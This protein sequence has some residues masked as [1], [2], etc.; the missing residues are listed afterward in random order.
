M[1]DATTP[2]AQPNASGDILTGIW[3]TLSR[4]VA[5]TK[6][7]WHWPVLATVKSSASGPSSST[8]VVVLRAFNAANRLIEIHSDSRAAKIAELQTGKASV[9]FYDHRARTQLRVEAHATVSINNSI[10][11]AAWAKL[12]E[13]GRTQYLGNEAP[14]SPLTNQL[15]YGTTSYFAVIQLKIESLDWLVLAR[16]GHKRME[17]FWDDQTNAF[18]A[19]TLVP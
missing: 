8:R 9:L 7:D 11:Q 2:R 6:H 15:T 12:P 17:F 5:D 18:T 13:H 4:G 10:S 3:A 19:T 16:D 14:G 1:T